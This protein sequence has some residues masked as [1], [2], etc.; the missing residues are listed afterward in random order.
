MENI[1]LIAKDDNCFPKPEQNRVLFIDGLGFN[2]RHADEL[3]PAALMMTVF[4]YI[5]S[6]KFTSLF[7]NLFGNE[8]VTTGLLFQLP[9]N[10][11]IRYNSNNRLYQDA[12]CNDVKLFSVLYGRDYNN[13]RIS[14]DLLDDKLSSKDLVIPELETKFDEANLYRYTESQEWVE[15]N[16]TQLPND[17]KSDCHRSVIKVLRSLFA[18]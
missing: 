6:V 4:E 10:Y 12:Y 15:Y 7:G 18:T 11:S 17:L 5:G 2:F 3:L 8:T 16:Q 13:L 9:N 1:D 14:T